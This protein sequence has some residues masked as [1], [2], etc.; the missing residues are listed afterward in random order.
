MATRERRLLEQLVKSWAQDHTDQYNI[1]DYTA[2]ETGMSNTEG[3]LTWVVREGHANLDLLSLVDR[4]EVFL[5]NRRQSKQ[6]DGMY[7]QKCHS[8]VE[9]AEPNQDDGSMICY[10]CR[11]NPYV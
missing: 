6:L 2:T 4:I 3:H 9:F 8:F 7:C 10:S 5:I 1:A 11:S